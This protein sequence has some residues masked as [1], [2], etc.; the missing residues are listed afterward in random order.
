MLRGRESR[1]TIKGERGGRGWRC[2]TTFVLSAIPLKIT[3][4]DDH[5][6]GDTR[7]ESGHRKQE[8]GDLSQ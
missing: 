6:D 2:G 5:V 8:H 3:C 1:G 4:C 7:H